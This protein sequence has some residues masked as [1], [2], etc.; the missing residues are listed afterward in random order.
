MRT[1]CSGR[2]GTGTGYDFPPARPSSS[3]SRPRGSGSDPG[4]EDARHRGRSSKPS[5]LSTIRDGGAGHLAGKACS[6]S[7]GKGLKRA[8]ATAGTKT[9][10]VQS[11]RFV[12]VFCTNALLL[13]GLREGP[14]AQPDAL[15]IEGRLGQ[16]GGGHLAAKDGDMDCLAGRHAA[17]F[18]VAQ[19][20]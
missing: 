18:H 19:G 11:V 20:E 17:R 15:G 6:P 5:T 10:Q 13:C 14:V 8:Q 12:G 3:Q 4:R 9:G 7:N 2:R 16:P 1:A